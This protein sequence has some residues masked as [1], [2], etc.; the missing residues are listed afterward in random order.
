MEH[1]RVIDI[2]FDQGIM[3]VVREDPPEDRPLRDDSG[4]IITANLDYVLESLAPVLE[5]HVL[6][7]ELHQYIDLRAVE[8]SSL[9]MH[10]QS[11]EGGV[12]DAVQAREELQQANDALQ[13]NADLM[14]DV[15]DTLIRVGFIRPLQECTMNNIDYDTRG[16]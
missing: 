7:Q 10:I 14:N 1:Y 9:D 4:N 6:L 15:L 3:L 2:D 12:D 5:L 8:I 13:E 11:A 16:Q